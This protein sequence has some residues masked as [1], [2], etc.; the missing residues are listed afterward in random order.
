MK[1][2]TS[3]SGNLVQLCRF[4]R[5]KGFS[6]SAADESNA[7]SA[8]KLIPIKKES[9]FRMCL[10]SIF[11]KSKY[12]QERFDEYYNEFWFQLAKAVDS[13]VKKVPEK[14]QTPA[15]KKEAQFDSIK[16]WLN[17]EGSTEEKEIAAPSAIELLSKKHFEELSEEELRLMMQLLRKMAKKITHTK[18]RLRQKSKKQKT[19]DLKRTMQF[20][21]RKGKDV[22]RFIFS[23]NKNKKL[24]LVL[25]CDVSK[26]MDLYSRFFIHL[27]Y[28][29]Q[30]SYD[31][32][33]TFV[34]STA[35]HEVTEILNNHE[36]EQAFEMISDRV[37]QWSGGTSIGSCFQ[38]FVKDFGYQKL[39]KKT[40]VLILSDGWDTGKPAV[41]KSAMQQIYKQTKKIIWLN[42][43]AG[44]E[45]FSPE[46]LGL[47]TALPYVDVLASAHNLESLK[48][49]MNQIGRRRSLQ[50]N[51][52]Y[53]E[54]N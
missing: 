19:L 20:N 38:D 49:A 16:K 42:P 48:L 50:P 32:I 14:K 35:L 28:A 31:K 47:K 51:N 27:I 12:Q 17:L 26:S 29:F 46:A 34:F 52:Q 15:Q 5:R 13:K 53:L 33:S 54:M 23:E 21:L 18:S 7:L 6:L 39:D 10:K 22:Q 9:N 45:N 2:Q 25:L 41:M 4:L 24:K 36:F 30:N 3:I 11:P 40:V 37:P 8:L 43:L 44:N 1:R